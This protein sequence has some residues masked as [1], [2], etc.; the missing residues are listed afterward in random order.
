MPVA[1]TARMFPTFFRHTTIE[2]ADKVEN[3][4]IDIRP[5]TLIL[6]GIRK[7][8]PKL[9]DLRI[10]GDVLDKLERKVFENLSQLETLD[11]S[12]MIIGSLESEAFFDLVNLE[13]LDL[14]NCKIENLDKNAFRKLAN[15]KS[16]NLYGNLLTKL[17][18]DLFKFNTKLSILSLRNNKL[19]MIKVDFSGISR[20]RLIDLGEN[21]CIDESYAK[22][23]TGF[24][25][26]T[27]VRMLQNKINENCSKSV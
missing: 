10:K 26:I 23:R 15:L 27:S 1:E 25:T 24:V 19:K 6:D 3:L 12:N 7:T 11:L 4:E 16:L 22:V 5:L 14:R 17:Q 20:I 8:F 21:E 2:K 18:Q 9:L 13:K